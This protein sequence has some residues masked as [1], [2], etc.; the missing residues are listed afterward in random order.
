MYRAGVSADHIVYFK[1]FA[2]QD[3]GYG[4]PSA[5]QHYVRGA[6]FD[7]ICLCGIWCNVGDIFQVFQEV[8][9]VNKGPD[10][11]FVLW[12]RYF[13]DMESVVLIKTGRVE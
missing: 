7:N 2:A 9:L 3:A 4:V 1:E 13:P 6:A 8:S 11:C 5:V 12:F 10:G